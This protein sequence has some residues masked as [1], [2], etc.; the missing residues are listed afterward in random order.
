M[1]LNTDIAAELREMG[2]RSAERLAS[3]RAA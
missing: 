3:P 1:I 2:D